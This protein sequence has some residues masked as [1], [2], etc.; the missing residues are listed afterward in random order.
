VSSPSSRYIGAELLEAELLEDELLDDADDPA[1]ALFRMKLPPDDA[2]PVVPV[3]P[4]A[5]DEL[6]AR[7]IQPV[8]VT[9]LSLWLDDALE[10][11]VCGVEL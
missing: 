8:I 7:W 4:V 1:V 10:L 2:L 6:G 9:D 5:L 11:G 3:V